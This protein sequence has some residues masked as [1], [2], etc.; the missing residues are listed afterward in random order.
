[1]FY[2]FKIHNDP[3]GFWAECIELDGCVTQGDTREELENNMHEALN[4]YLDEPTDLDSDEPLPDDN[5]KG[6]NIVKVPVEPD[7][8][9][10]VLVRHYR[11]VKN[12]SQNDVAEILGMKNIFS[13]QRLE[14]KTNPRLSTLKKIKEIFPEIS[15]DYILQI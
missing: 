4:I 6:K 8:A 1:M 10:S 5:L 7:I 12:L 14:R 9:F 2:H 3:D 13:Y 11:K 15:I